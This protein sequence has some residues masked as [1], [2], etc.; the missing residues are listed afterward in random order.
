[1]MKNLIE[2]Q[3]KNTVRLK[4][5]F[6]NPLSALKGAT[7]LVIKTLSIMTLSIMGLLTTLSTTVSSV[8][9]LLSVIRLCR[10]F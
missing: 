4:W 6:Y 3:T 10:V 5:S 9:M 2:N 1:M 7:T 8:V